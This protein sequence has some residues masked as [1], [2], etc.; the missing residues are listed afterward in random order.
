MK[1]F[2]GVGEHRGWNNAWSSD[3][4]VCVTQRESIVSRITLHFGAR[5]D[6]ACVYVCVRARGRCVSSNFGSR[7]FNAARVTRL[8]RV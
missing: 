4:F 5:V 7:L 2:P 6:D 8:P 3:L 1:G